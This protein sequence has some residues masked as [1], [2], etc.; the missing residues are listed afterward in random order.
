MG[1][2]YNTKLKVKYTDEQIVEFKEKI[3]DLI[4]TGTVKTV[5]E[6]ARM[7]GISP[8]RVHEW[9]RTDTIFR[10]IVRLARKVM[11][12]K[13]FE[14]L[15]NTDPDAKMPAVT[16]K[17]FLL[18]GLDPEFRDNYKVLEIKDEKVQK[19]LDE[20]R[21]LGRQGDIEAK[22]GG[23]KQKKVEK[24]VENTHLAI[25]ERLDNEGEE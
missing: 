22:K 4:D 13:L 23:S 12:D 25:I 14:E 5:S 11:A 8:T 2:K 6:A 16:A 21:N 1:N 19:M 3:V 17:I 15:Y 7:L 18:K 9:G 10:N 24:S 20:L